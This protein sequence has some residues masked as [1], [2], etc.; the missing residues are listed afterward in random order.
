[1][2]HSASIE[3]AALTSPP[4]I[5]A[6]GH[7]LLTISASTPPSRP[8]QFIGIRISSLA[9]PL[10][11]RPFS[12]FDHSGDTLRIVVKI[13]GRGTAMLAQRSPG[14]LDIIGPLGNGFTILRG[15][16]VMLI[17][18]GVGNAPLHYLAGVL[19]AATCDVTY[20]YG[21][22][23]AEAIFC[24]DSFEARANRF[25][26]VTDDGSRGRK[27]LAADAAS[28][29][30]QS[31]TFDMIYACGP[32]P[33]LRAVAGLARRSGIPAEVSMENYFGCG[34]GVCSACTVHTAKG[35]RRA[36]VEGPVFDAA[37]LVMDP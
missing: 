25:I 20:I 37:S 26:T 12:I 29:L 32:Q 16:R 14:P 9:D 28:G 27:G 23:S 1:M 33:M 24:P 21:A 17:G 18:G 10:L 30:I 5:I 3:G 11:R 13:V 8:G 6:A 15:S 36:C 7:C 2:K 4:Q 31:E 19:S 22:R 34:I 35:P